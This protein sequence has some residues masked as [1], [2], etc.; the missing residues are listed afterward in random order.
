MTFTPST[1][2]DITEG[3]PAEFTTRTDAASAVARGRIRWDLSVGGIGFVLAINDQSPYIRESA[4]VQKQQFDTSTEAGEQTLEGYWLRSQTSWHLGAGANFY[5]PGVRDELAVPSRYRFASSA[6]VDPWTEG[7]LKLLKKVTLKQAGAGECYVAAARTGGTD[8]WFAQNSG[9][10]TRYTSAGAATNYTPSSA[11][12]KGR[13]A[14]AGSKVL[15]SHDFGIDVGDVSGS[16]LTRLYTQT[17]GTTPQPYWVKGR[18][19]AH[20]GR[21]LYELALD[22]SSGTTAGNLDTVPVLHTHPDTGWTWTSVAE[23]PSAILA[24]GHAGGVG[25]IYAFTLED[26]T[27][28]STPKLGA[29][30]QVAEFPPGEEIHS[31]RVYLGTYIGIG[32][33]K[34]VRVGLIG[35]GGQVQYGP[36]LVEATEPVRSLA[37]RDRFMYAAITN[38]IDGQSGCVRIDLGSPLGGD[39][40]LFPW[41]FDAQTHDTGTVR[42]ISFVGHS[43]RVVMGVDAKGAYVQSAT[44]YE[45]EGYLLSGSIRFATTEPKA[46]RY[47]DV[48][49]R[50]EAGGTVALSVEDPLGGKYPVVTLGKGVDG[51]NI[52]I[53]RVPQRLEHLAYKLVLKSS[54]DLLVSP[55]V[56]SI[57]IKA[58]P[59]PKKQRMFRYPV[60][61]A[62]KFL[63]PYGTPVGVDGY[64]YKV[65]EALEDLEDTLAV[66]QVRD[67]RTGEQFSGVIE[68]FRFVGTTP[69][70]GGRRGGGNFGGN[71]EITLRKV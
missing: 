53:S 70:S 68:S 46:F 50:T 4:P 32:T 59:A 18:I 66:V 36:L 49:A 23:S 1:P 25:A 2:K 42:S 58:M 28:G 41:A 34:G 15:T 71:G 64:A 56:E 47:A 39:S 17:L 69:G 37:A 6:G 12:P 54:A 11:A 13:V 60:K 31:I 22:G 51:S 27:S 19:V 35:D 3:L 10:L 26:P 48:R 33:S 55:V 16:A 43:D 14:I 9:T 52:S 29:A 67:Y 44:Q 7:D 20:K 30:F 65:T 45:T 62:D 63:D 40:L 38:G 21:S 5:E 8:V 24:A 57:G 61:L